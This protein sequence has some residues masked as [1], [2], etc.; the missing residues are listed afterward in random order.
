[1]SRDAS[2]CCFGRIEIQQK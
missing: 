1:V 2:G